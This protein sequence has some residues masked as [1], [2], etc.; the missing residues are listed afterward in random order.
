MV[1]FVGIY[2]RSGIARKQK[3]LVF[4]PSIPWI[5]CWVDL[6]VLGIPSAVTPEFLHHFREENLITPEGEYEEEYVL[7]APG[8]SDRV[9]YINHDGGPRWLWM[10]DFLI[11]KL[12]I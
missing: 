7:E 2:P 12:G 5:Y 8:P 9:C 1:S 3:T 11:A 6:E 10:Y 4:P